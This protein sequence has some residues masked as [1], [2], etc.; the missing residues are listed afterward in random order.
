MARRKV[1]IMISSRCNDT[2]PAAGGAG[3]RTLSQIRAQLKREIESEKLFG[4]EAF[5][6]WINEDE[7]PELTGPQ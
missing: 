4:R 1:K 6:V 7:P 5:E 2:F 3:S